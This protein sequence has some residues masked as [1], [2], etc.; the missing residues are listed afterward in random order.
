MNE[1]TLLIPSISVCMAVFNG[2][3]YL[4][5]QISSIL[6]EISE[7][8]EL[9]IVDDCSSDSTV[10]IVKNFN[11]QRIK[12]YI[13]DR[14]YRHVYSFGQAITY[15]NNSVIFLSDQD[16]IW[17]PG[18]VTRM[19]SALRSS[20]VS[21]VTSNF[22]WINSHGECIEIRYDGVHSIDSRRW[23]KNILDIYIGKTNY[24]GCAMLL[25]KDLLYFVLPIPKYVES[26][27]LWIALAANL[28]GSNQHL[29]DR[30]FKKRHHESNATSTISTRP[31][32]RKLWAR[33]IFTISLIHL[34]I[35][36][37]CIRRE[38]P[39]YG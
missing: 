17:N 35:R 5:E 14:N 25:S 8:D 12:L 21:L 38:L 9:V 3:K 7:R 2:E 28:I 6:S 1:E 36:K 24:Y 11:D 26:H 31:I 19:L 15:A 33:V 27:D 39:K 16:D 30:T 13:N 37:L 34:L 4:S 22:D 32:H 10:D 29:D 18:R 20:K 23:I